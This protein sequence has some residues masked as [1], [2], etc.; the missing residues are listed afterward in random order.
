MKILVLLSILFLVPSVL[1]AVDSETD[2][3]SKVQRVYKSDGNHRYGFS[4][5]VGSEVSRG[6]FEIVGGTDTRSIRTVLVINPSS[7]YDLCIA[8]FSDFTVG[9]DNCWIVPSSS[10]SW[11]TSNHANFFMKY[12]S[13]ASSDTVKGNVESE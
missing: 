7:V 8:T 3:N 9:I 12:P 13:G 1:L 10:G 11:S 4:V 2:L 6:L 5:Q